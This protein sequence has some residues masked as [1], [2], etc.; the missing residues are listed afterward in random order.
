LEFVWFFKV[1]SEDGDEF[2]EVLG[3]PEER[4]PVGRDVVD[5]KAATFA[6]SVYN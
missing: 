2:I 4:L 6:F 3:E 5:H 1:P